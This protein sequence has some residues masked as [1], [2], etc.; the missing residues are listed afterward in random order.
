M[1]ES[2][3]H[4]MQLSQQLQATAMRVQEMTGQLQ[5]YVREQQHVQDDVLEIRNL[6]RSMNQLLNE[7]D[8][9]LRTRVFWM[10]KEIGDIK[11]SKSRTQDWWL[12]LCATLAGAAILALLGF[13]LLLYA[14]QK[15]GPI[16]PGM[17]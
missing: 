13:M 11:A 14:A 6:V 10:E 7:G 8:P 5:G 15:G 4:V 17:P 9:S 3:N 2:T 12:K 1:G 16:K